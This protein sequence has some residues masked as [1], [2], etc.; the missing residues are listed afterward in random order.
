MRC[1]VGDPGLSGVRDRGSGIGRCE[2]DLGA[3]NV[4]DE[5][6]HRVENRVR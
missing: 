4:G 3:A 5:E 2:E 1:G 6:A